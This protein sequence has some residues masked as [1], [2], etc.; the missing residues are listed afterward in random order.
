MSIQRTNAVALHHKGMSEDRAALVKR[1]HE[2]QIS[3]KKRGQ[4]SCVFEQGQSRLTFVTELTVRMIGKRSKE[5]SSG[6]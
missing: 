5:E 2:D 3:I 1:F 4:D 6:D